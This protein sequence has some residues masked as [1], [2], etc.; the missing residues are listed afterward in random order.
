MRC[1]WIICSDQSSTLQVRQ[2]K[3]IQ[4]SNASAIISFRIET[5]Y[6]QLHEHAV[7]LFLFGKC[8]F[9]IYPS[10]HLIFVVVQPKCVRLE[11]KFA[12]S[13]NA[14]INPEYR[15]VQ[16]MRIGHIVWHKIQFGCNQCVA[17]VTAQ[18]CRQNFLK[19]ANHVCR[20]LEINWTKRMRTLLNRVYSYACEILNGNGY[21]GHTSS[22]R[23]DP[24]ATVSV[25]PSAVAVAVASSSELQNFE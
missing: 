7:S 21:K 23:R 19:S 22:H 15:S 24:I 4:Q 6:T 14:S 13:Q 3:F 16:R 18:T 10:S 2:R 11:C 17:W 1:K 12:R 5:T 20:W 9:P 25:S 8:K